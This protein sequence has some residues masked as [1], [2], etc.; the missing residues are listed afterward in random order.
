MAKPTRALVPQWAPPE[1]PD[2]APVLVLGNSLGTTAMVWDSQIPIFRQHYRVLSFDLPGHA[3]SAAL[4]GPYTLE[5]LGSGVLAM[6]DTLSIERASYCGV[7][8]GGMIGMWLASRAPSRITALG[9]VCTSAHLPPAAGWHSRAARVRVDGL[10]A[11][12]DQ[13]VNRWFTPA[14]VAEA[15]A[16]PDAFQIALELTDPEGYAGCCEAIAD[17]DLRADLGAISAPTLVMAGANDPATPP[18]HGDA[19]AECIPGAS[20]QVIPGAAHLATV[21]NP[22]VVGHALAAHLRATTGPEQFWRAGR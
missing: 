9:L 21:S 6:L 1:G 17:M 8:L 13:V 4:P 20:L 11:I 2:G 12:S 18:E 19:I 14:Y 15:P 3:G 5:E 22:D 16:V 10:S 7:S